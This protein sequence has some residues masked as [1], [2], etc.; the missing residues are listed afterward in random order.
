MPNL[1][2]TTGSLI[3]G[4]W[5]V[6]DYNAGSSAQPPNLRTLLWAYV[7]GAATQP[8]N[9]PFR[10]TSQTDLNN[11]VGGANNDAARSYAACTSQPESQ[12]SDIWMV[13]IP[14]PSGGQAATYK[15]TVFV[16]NTNPA[17]PGTLQLWIAGQQVPSIGFSASDTAT[18]IGAALATAI[19]ATPNAPFASAANAAGIVTCT[20]VH[21]GTTGE[22]LPMRC[23]ITPN[24]SGVNLSPGQALFATSATGVGSVVVT[25]GA[26]SVS[27]ALAGSETAAQVATKVVAN[28]NANAY[29]VTAVV[30]ASVPAQVDFYFNSAGPT[31][32][33]VRRMSAAVVTTTGLTVN[34]GSGATSGAGSASSLTYNGT[35]GTGTPALTTAVAN[36]TASPQFYRSWM[37][38]WT[39]TTTLG[40]IATYVEAAQNGSVTGQKFQVVTFADFQALS[41]DLAIPAAVSPN[42]N[43]S[44]P[45]YA[46]GWSPDSPCQSFELAAR[47]A[48]A[49]AA[50]WFSAPQFNWNG[51]K[52]QGNQAAPIL[53]PA[54][55]AQPAPDALNTALR[56]GLSPWV[57]G[58]SGNIEVLKGRTT[59][60]AADLRLWAWSAESCAAY[61][62]F[63]LNNFLASKTQGANIVRYTT[64]KAVNQFDANSIADLT[65]ER[66]RFWEQNGNYDGAT[67]FAPE[68]N[69]VPNAINPFR[70]DLDWPESPPLDLDQ[71][72]HSSHFSQPS[73]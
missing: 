63:D 51:F 21:K 38:P 25:V 37:I 69:A 42:L 1:G 22:D 55:S 53:A 71:I 26:I 10:V 14:E 41:I 17:K 8:P 13:T 49:R 34:L 45:H 70:I 16:S 59:S 67:L 47:I 15:L 39:D 19:L 62:V 18:T 3:P 40:T 46:F 2:L 33:D 52:L 5:G 29:P 43:T 12:G 27:T 11:R 48:A 30:D 6:V 4:Y 24:G 64:P 57:V 44:N 50:F 72:A 9:Q 7:P 28:W 56:G 68:V 32:Y 35:Q 73:S 58:R 60:T 65:R 61:H 66:M 36:L 20:Y 54:P 23:Q 31:L